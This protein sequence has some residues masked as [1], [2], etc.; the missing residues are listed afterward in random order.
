MFFVEKPNVM[1]IIE[2]I[3]EKCCVT[4]IYNG[5]TL[6]QIT[7]HY[8]Y[9]AIMNAEKKVVFFLA[10]QGYKEHLLLLLCVYR[11]PVS[12]QVLPLPLMLLFHPEFSLLVTAPLVDQVALPRWT[13]YPR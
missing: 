1:D 9:L 5:F 4:L 13:K 2:N 11:K 6:K 7:S 8:K 3:C 10:I 12:T